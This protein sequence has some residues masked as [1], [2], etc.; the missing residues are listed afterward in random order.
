MDP[1]HGFIDLTQVEAEII[2]LPVFKRLEGIKQ[3]SLTN[4]IFPGAEHTRYIH[5]IGV[6]YICDEMA[7][8]IKWIDGTPRFNDGQRQILRLAGLLHDIGH[9]PLSHLT[10]E[11]YME[12]DGLKEKTGNILNNYHRNV[13]SSIEKMEEISLPDYMKNRSSKKMHHETMGTKIIRSDITI[14]E[15]IKKYC[16]FVNIDDICDII[17]GSV[18]NVRDLES[19]KV[20]QDLSVMVQ[21]MHSELDA[22]GIDYILRDATFSGTSYGAFTLGILL[23]HLTV[24]EYQGIEIVGLRPKAISTVDQYLLSKHFSYTQVIFN[25][26]VAILEAMANIFTHYL[27][28]SDAQFGFLT[29]DKLEDY[30]YKHERHLDYLQFTDRKFWRSLDT[31]DIDRA[32]DGRPFMRCI[33]E[34]LRKYEELPLI[35]QKENI[36]TDSDQIKVMELIKQTDTYHM[37]TEYPQDKLFVFHKKPITSE[38]KQETFNSMLAEQ[39]G[40]N[41]ESAEVK[42]QKIKRLQEGI[43]VIENNDDIHL[44]VD[45]S[46]SLISCMENVTTFILRGYYIE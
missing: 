20:N 27:F 13:I 30:A 36:W 4:W 3:L 12:E 5:S 42:N 19:G 40:G 41:L 43:C 38:L 23:R 34:H 28:E 9:Y 17:V 26:H 24:V 39:N 46:R 6:M 18:E 16:P 44:L 8:H 1:V 32:S 45:D 10:E 21:L 31:E 35:D 25:R 37:L 11:V 29:P 15:I 22:D 33:I 2:Q 14:Q 7:R